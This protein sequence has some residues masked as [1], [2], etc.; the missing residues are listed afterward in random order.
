MTSDD[1]INVMVINLAI[2]QIMQVMICHVMLINHAQN[3]P[4]SHQIPPIVTKGGCYGSD[5]TSDI[6]NA[7]GMY[8]AHQAKISGEQI[9]GFGVKSLSFAQIDGKHLPKM[10][11]NLF[12]EQA[13]YGAQIY[14]Q[15]SIKCIINCKVSG[16]AVNICVILQ[17]EQNVIFNLCGKGQ[18]G[19]RM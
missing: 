6:I 5:I 10:E 13:G 3:R 12:G 15:R 14:C 7:Y 11:V 19:I 8:G 2:K 1:N 18:M 16:Y 9:N 4:Y 17:M